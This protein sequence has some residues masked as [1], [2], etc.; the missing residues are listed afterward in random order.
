[1]PDL[2]FQDFAVREV[3][4]LT[5]E[6]DKWLWECWGP[7]QREYN[8]IFGRHDAVVDFISPMW[9]DS[10]RFLEPNLS[11]IGGLHLVPTA[12]RILAEIVFPALRANDSQLQLDIGQDIR[13]LLMQDVLEHLEALHR[14]ARNICFVE[15]RDDSGPLEQEALAQYFHDRYG[16]KV[17]HADP[18]ELSLQGDE[19]YCAG[20]P[21]DL[22]YRDYPVFDLI[23]AEKEGLDVR[24]MRAL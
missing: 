11:G 13:E 12:E 5:P 4:R 8:P 17:M 15:P 10:L 2:Y 22:V 14:P 19:V 16:L 20:L 7:N 23:E 9:K 1:L 21:I 3:L 18:H 24:P 6:E